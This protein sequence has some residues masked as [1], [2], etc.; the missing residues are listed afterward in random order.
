VCRF[1]ALELRHDGW[2]HQEITEAL[3]V[4]KGAVSQWMTRVAIEGKANLI[5]LAATV[6]LAEKPPGAISQSL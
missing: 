2:T 3:G 5:T 4:T 6:G 1:R